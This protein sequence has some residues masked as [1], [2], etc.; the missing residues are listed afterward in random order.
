[1]HPL[2]QRW[3]TYRNEP[4]GLSGAEMPLHKRILIPLIFEPGTSWNYGSGMDWVGVL[5][6]RLSKGASLQEY[7]QKNLW[8]PLGIKDITFHWEL[9]PSMQERRVALSRRQ[10]PVDVWGMSE[11]PDD[12]VAWTDE[13]LYQDPTTDEY[14][15]H[16]AIASATD[17]LKILQSILTNDGRLLQPATVDQMFTPQLSPES[18]ESLAANLTNAKL[19]AML[20][21]GPT[22]VK[23][24]WGLGGMMILEDLPTGRKKGS[25]GWSGLPNLHWW[26][27]RKTELCGMYATQVLPYGDQKSA[28]MQQLWEKEMYERLEKL[29]SR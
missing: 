20:W 12:K 5:V 7:M 22:G 29:R 2:L 27:D 4:L 11:N 9:N 15:G 16:G 3:R 6:S 21:S 14:G 26:I 25:I 28:A 18:R 23:V 10:G 19:N 24:D 1:M 17:Y 13:V 8:A